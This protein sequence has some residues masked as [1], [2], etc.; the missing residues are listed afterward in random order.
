[1]SER[2]DGNVLA[3]AVAEALGVDITVAVRTCGS[4]ATT[5]PGGA[6]LVYVAAGLVMRCPGCGDVA[7]VVVATDTGHAVRLRGDWELRAG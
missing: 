7:A 6:H 3:G 5:A 4:C 2:L 1:M